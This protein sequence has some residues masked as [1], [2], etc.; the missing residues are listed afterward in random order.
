MKALEQL[1][2][3]L[4][5]QRDGLA[6]LLDL[7]ARERECL[8][9][10]GIAELDAIT[11]AQAELLARQ[12]WLCTQTFTALEALAQRLEMPPHT[13]L[14]ELIPRLDAETGARIQRRAQGLTELADAVQREGRVN[15]H[16]AQQ[17]LRYVDFTLK[18]IGQAKEGPHPY[19][20]VKPSAP[21]QGARLLMN[22]CA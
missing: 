1:E 19:A 5:A 15:W 20:P 6:R 13:A 7:C 14:S 3:L 2:R 12:A 9:A 17:A 11:H 21:Q 4:E 16:L 18:V 10:A 8:L 22:S